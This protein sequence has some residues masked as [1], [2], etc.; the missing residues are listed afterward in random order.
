MGRCEF[1]RGGVWESGR[2]FWVRAELY[3]EG[4]FCYYDDDCFCGFVGFGGVIDN[5]GFCSV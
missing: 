1:K 5:L 3:K 2:K 4:Y